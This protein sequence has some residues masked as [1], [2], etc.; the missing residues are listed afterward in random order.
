MYR[1]MFT[2][3]RSA[4]AHKLELYYV[5][6]LLCHV[7]EGTISEGGSRSERGGVNKKN[8]A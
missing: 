7:S 8:A 4:Q 5:G 3:A 2:E 6:L 1:Y